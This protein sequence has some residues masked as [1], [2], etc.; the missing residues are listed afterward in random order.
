MDE[1]IEAIIDG[2]GNIE[3]KGIGLQKCR[4]MD[5]SEWTEG[6]GCL[7]SKQEGLYGCLHE[8]LQQ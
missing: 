6:S 1:R 2:E 3:I 8:I 4:N 7:Y 5:V